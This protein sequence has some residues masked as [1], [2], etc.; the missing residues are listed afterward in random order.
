M[1]RISTLQNRAE[2]ARRT[3]IERWASGVRGIRVPFPSRLGL[4]EIA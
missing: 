2:T 4:D 3:A 1:S